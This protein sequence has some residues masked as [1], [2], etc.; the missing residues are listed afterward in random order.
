MN[1]LIFSTLQCH[2]QGK[3]VQ[4]FCE[5]VILIAGNSPKNTEKGNPSAV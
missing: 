4:T 1:I 2:Y 5:K 3:Y